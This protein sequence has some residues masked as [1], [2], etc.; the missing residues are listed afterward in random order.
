MSPQDIIQ[1][2][3]KFMKAVIVQTTTSNEE[4]AKK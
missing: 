4:E 2:I 1:G 3:K